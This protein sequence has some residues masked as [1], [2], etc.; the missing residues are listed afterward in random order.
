MVN[1]FLSFLQVLTSV[2]TS[3]TRRPA[4]HVVVVDFEKSM[5]KGIRL[6]LPGITIKG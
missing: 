3:M 2:V 6:V 5:W 4:V 1:L